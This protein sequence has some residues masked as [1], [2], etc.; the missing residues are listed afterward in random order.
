MQ[1]YIVRNI[2]KS[3]NNSLDN[4]ILGQNL[5]FEWLGNEVSCGVDMQRIDV[6][7]STNVNNQRVLIPIELKSVEADVINAK[8]IQ[9]Y[10][11]WIEQYYTPNRQSDIQPVLISKKVENKQAEKYQKIIATFKEFNTQNSRRCENLKYVEYYLDGDNLVF[12][13]VNY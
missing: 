13:E 9:R 10:I 6:M 1:A 3:I 7:I 8:Q 4:C 2:G 11:D 12:E 5:N